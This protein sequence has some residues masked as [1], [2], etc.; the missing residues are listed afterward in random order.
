[1]TV[2]FEVDAGFLAREDVPLGPGDLA[3]GF[4]RGWIDAR[5]VID[6]AV[7]ELRRGSN[8]AVIEKLALLLPPD[9]AAVP[10]ILSEAGAS[11]APA[12]RKWLYLQLK[13]AYE[14]REDL[15]DPLAVVAEIYAEFDYPEEIAPFVHYMPVQAG[16]D[17]GRPAL[18]RRWREYLDAELAALRR[19]DG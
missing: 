18:M 17:T 1:M 5:T 10:E 8:D 16:Q 12:A 2:S 9:T 13:A 4:E 19:G 6:R 3:Y 15:A 11:Q 7:A 14:R